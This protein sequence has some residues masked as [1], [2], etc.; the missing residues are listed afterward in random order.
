MLEQS[1]RTVG[2]HLGH[3][4]HNPHTGAEAPPEVANHLPPCRVA[5]EGRDGVDVG[6]V[7]HVQSEPV[8]EARHDQAADRSDDV[9]LVE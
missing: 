2:D 7:G 9:V 1:W 4:R 3:L 8:R 6:A 5:V